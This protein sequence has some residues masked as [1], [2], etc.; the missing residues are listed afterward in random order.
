MQPGFGAEPLQAGD[1][2]P[3]EGARHEHHSVGVA[4]KL[5]HKE[6]GPFDPGFDVSSSDK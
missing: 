4:R 6:G 1:A 5:V 3:E 2:T